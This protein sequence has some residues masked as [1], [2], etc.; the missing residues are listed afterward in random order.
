MLNK[1]QTYTYNELYDNV[2]RLA[3]VLRTLGKKK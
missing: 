1:S 3:G 2:A